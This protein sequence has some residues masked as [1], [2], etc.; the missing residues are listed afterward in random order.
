MTIQLA[1]AFTMDEA[2]TSV[3]R[4]LLARALSH[5]CV[6]HH[7]YSE[8]EVAAAFD[9]S[10]ALHSDVS[11]NVLFAARLLGE[12]IASGEIHSWARPFGGGSPIPIPA[13]DWE[14]DDFRTRMAW[15]ALDPKR[16]FDAAA[17]PT[18]WI[19]IELCDFNRVV[20]LS[21]ADVLPP[22]RRRGS[23]V[24]TPVTA[25][26]NAAVEAVSEDRHIRMPEI[27][28]RTGMSSSTIYRRIAQGRFP[29]QI[30][31]ADGNIASWW[32]SDVAQWIANPR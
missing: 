30:P 29:K 26:A 13:G 28:R 9:P 10:S 1:S 15:S 24:L 22:R 17:E 6:L 23:D 21:C 8:E 3:G 25:S 12:L 31:M 5:W 19:F 4:I 14:L 7:G 18:H 32:E 20:E 16:P 2:P 11:S 27:I